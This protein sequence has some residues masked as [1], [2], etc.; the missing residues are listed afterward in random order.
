MYLLHKTNIERMDK[1]RKI[2]FW[3]G[4]N[5]KNKYHLVKWSKICKPKKKGGLRIKDLRKMNMSLLTK[6][7]W[8]IEYG[9][10]LWKEFVRKKYVKNRSISQIKHKQTDSPVWSDLLKVKDFYLNGRVV[11]IGNGK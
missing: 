4:G 11:I 5:V 1:I 3:L 9:E 8:K 6:W 10:G 2:F 7:W